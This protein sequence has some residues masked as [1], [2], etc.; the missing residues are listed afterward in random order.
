MKQAP[1]RSMLADE[2]SLRRLWRSVIVRA[3]LD[4][5]LLRTKGGDSLGEHQGLLEWPAAE[6]WIFD[7]RHADWLQEV[8]AAA[9]VDWHS[10][11]RVAR[12]IMDGDAATAQKLHRLVRRYFGNK[13]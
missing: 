11:R 4:L 2:V 12:R 3:L 9:G 6:D 7:A 10:V 1:T 8:C 13:E 5:D